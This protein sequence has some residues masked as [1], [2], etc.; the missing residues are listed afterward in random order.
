MNCID[1]SYLVRLGDREY[2]KACMID[3]D[4]VQSSEA[5]FDGDQSYIRFDFKGSTIESDASNSIQIVHNQETIEALWRMY[6]HAIGAASHIVTGY[7]AN[8]EAA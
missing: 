3:L 8:R 7:L 4:S 1:F 6:M 5:K 2:R